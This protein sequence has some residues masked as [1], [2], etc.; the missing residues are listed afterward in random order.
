MPHF[1]FKL[2][3]PRTTFAMDM[4]EEEKKLMQQHA[5]FWNDLLANGTALIYGPVLD[6]KGAY[7]LAIIEA[8]GES[9]AQ[10]ICTKDPTI[11]AKL[12]TYELHPMHVLTG[13]QIL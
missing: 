10:A 1:M 6:P 4:N 2:I 5:I 11:Q 3:A 13:Q 8:A 9:D 12:H 7:G